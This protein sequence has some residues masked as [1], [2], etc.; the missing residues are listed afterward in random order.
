MDGTDLTFSAAADYNGSENFTIS[1]TDGELT[2]SQVL[3]V[4][5]NAVNDAPVAG[6]GIT[7][8]TNEGSGISI[9]LS[10]S[11]VDGDNLTYTLLSDAT[12]GSVTIEGQLATYT[13][14][15]YYYGSD[16]F[17]FQVSDGELTDSAVV[18]LQINAVNDAPVLA[19]S[20]IHI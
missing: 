16:E 2:D 7:G 17:T 1:V 5:I 10:A 13:P 20:L 3:T 19:L 6:T 18:T 4:T 8:E 11:D 9:Q 15:D 12:N 14:Q